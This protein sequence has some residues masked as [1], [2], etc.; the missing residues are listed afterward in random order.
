V[1]QWQPGETV[2]LRYHARDRAMV[3]SGYPTTCVEDSDE[4]LVLFLP[5]NTTYIGYDH[6]PLEGRVQ[7][8][9][10]RAT[11]PMPLRRRQPHTWRNHTLRF[12]YPGEPYQ[13]WAAWRE[14]SWEFA[15]W[16]VNLEAPFIRTAVGVDTRDHTLDIVASADLKWR[17][18]DE[19]ELEA[20]IEHGI[21]TVE[22]AA[23]V[24]RHGEQAVELIE[25]VASPFSEPWADWRPDPT[26]VPP[27][28]PEDWADEPAPELARPGD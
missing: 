22:F 20:R 14:D 23:A 28:L 26:W 11:K 2:V 25:R 19:D 3:A 8:V 4:R 9:I 16:Y 7:H 13:V 17:W 27:V 10:D 21:D 15:W 5:H 1:T 18:K 12:L 24:R 6:L